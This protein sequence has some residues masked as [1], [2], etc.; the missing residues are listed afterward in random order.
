M[1]AGEITERVVQEVASGKYPFTLV[2][3]ANADMVAHTG[4]IEAVVEAV[5]FLD[6]MLGRITQTVLA[7]GGTVVVTAD[8][9]NAEE[10]LDIHSGEYLKEHTTNP[11]P[12]ILVNEQFRGK[13]DG[14]FQGPDFDLSRALP[15]G[16]L[17]DVAPT[18][19]KF[20][21]LPVPPEMTGTS[22]L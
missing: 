9:G 11:V 15:K 3:F 17:S 19:L 8:H 7:M 10:M 5:E 4:K 13:G 12:F 1:S 21:G 18:I 22:L 2:N 14:S 20:M 6:K 16:V